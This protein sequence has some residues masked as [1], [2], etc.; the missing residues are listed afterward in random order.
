[1]Y[2]LERPKIMGTNSY[3]LYL[4]Q[5]QECC[6]ALCIRYGHCLLEKVNMANPICISRRRRTYLHQEGVTF[7]SNEQAEQRN[8]TK[9]K[10]TRNIGSTYPKP[11]SL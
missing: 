3:D 5:V 6:P 4:R 9:S 2:T 7:E 10:D 1:M 8:S 11:C